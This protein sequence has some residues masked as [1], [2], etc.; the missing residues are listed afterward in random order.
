VN[1]HAQNPKFTAIG[2]SALFLELGEAAVSQNTATSC[3]WST[4][5][6]GLVV[7]TDTSTGGSLTDTGS[8]WVVWVP[9]AGNTCATNATPAQVFAYLQ[10]DSVVGDR[11]LF[12][13]HAGTQLCKISY[14]AAAGTAPANKI[15]PA[16]N[17]AL[18]TAITEVALPAAVG[19]SLTNTIVS[20][21]GT[22]IRPED[23]LF[24]T[25]RA[26]TPCGSSAG[27]TGSIA[28]YLGLGYTN[29][30]DILSDNSA[31]LF[32]VI[33]FSLPSTYFVT[34]IGVDPI[35]VVAHSTD[36]AGTGLSF[37]N[38]A[39]PS[40]SRITLAQYLDGSMGQSFG[41]VPGQ[42]TGNSVAVTTFVREPLSGTYNTMEYNVPNTRA[43]ETSQ[44]VGVNQISSQVNCSGSVPLSNP[45]HIQNVTAGSVRSRAIGTGE[46]LKSVFNNND[47]LGYGFWGVSNYA[48]AT[49]GTR[50]FQVDGWDPLFTYA[51]TATV[52]AGGPNNG[53]IPKAGTGDLPKITFGHLF[54]GNYPIWSLIRLVT[55]DVN[56]NTNVAK[57]L[58]LAA[59]SFSQIGSTSPDFLPYFKPDGSVQLAIER[60]HFAPPG[61]NFSATNIP[62][63]HGYS[64]GFGAC[65]TAE[66]GGDVGGV[67]VRINPVDQEYCADTGV[68]T[69]ITGRRY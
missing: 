11:C 5:T 26:L 62:A 3:V 52:A 43:A 32:H 31:A 55:V 28:P 37:S 14:A 48:G 63:N 21:A 12:N 22:D 57:K 40:V 2:S 60:S 15:A 19:T 53:F 64:Q 18:G 38:T 66:S 25:T 54:D 34:P 45:L 59:A 46:E 4:G 56:G 23:A 27:G 7:A 16:V 35:L 42:T 69:G 8:S 41:L 1:V 49:T 65:T 36:A 47:T 30:S 9:A 51:N 13:A 6:N 68:T 20:A 17:A 33:N 50:Y 29:G 61:I 39:L 67:P 24:A 58:A 44:D 10:T